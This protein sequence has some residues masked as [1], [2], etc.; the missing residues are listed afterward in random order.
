MEQ[1]GEW[2]EV[3]G[4]AKVLPLPQE[5][6]D[7]Y[8]AQYNEVDNLFNETLNGLQDLDVPSGFAGQETKPL[9]L[10][11]HQRGHSRKI[12][13]TAIFGYA[14]HTRELSVNGLT[15]DFYKNGKPS[16]DLGKS[17]SPGQLLKNLGNSSIQTNNIATK[18]ELVVPPPILLNEEDE[19]EQQGSSSSNTAKQ[20]DKDYIVTNMCPKSYKFPPSPSPTR[21]NGNEFRMSNDN[22]TNF[23]PVNSY[24]AKYL[25]NLRYSDTKRAGIDYVDDITPLLENSTNEHAIRTNH[26]DNITGFQ[27]DELLSML[28]TPFS[29]QVYKYVSIPVQEPDAQ[30]KNIMNNN[31]QQEFKNEA[32]ILPPP[33]PP[34][35]SNGSP[36]WQSSPEPQSPSPVRTSLGKFSSPDKGLANHKPSFYKLQFFSDP[37]S[38][39]AGIN[40][41]DYQIQSS[42]VYEASSLN[43]SPI[44]YYDKDSK[45]MFNDD[46]LVDANATITQ[47]TPLKN[48][49]PNTPSKNNVTLEWSP[50]ISPN[51]KA[52]K[53]VKKH[54][55]QTTLRRKVKKTSLLPPGELD[56]F[57]EGPD[58]NKV[59]TCT[60][61][62]CGK[63]FT[64]RYNVRSHIQTHLSDRPFACSYCPKKFVR[65]HDLNRHVKGHLDARYCKCPCGKEFA[66]LDAM[67]K[68]RERNICIGG[69]ASNTNNYVT[70]PQKKGKHETLDS[71]KC[72]KLNE[73]LSFPEKLNPFLSET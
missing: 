61:R 25:Q 56:R 51:E 26:Q 49:F 1:Y 21:Y 11:V 22:E 29:K 8:F 66:R 12:S 41:L 14:E 47:L 45:E 27:Q 71:I 69:I 5:E 31:F 54:I 60:Y 55:Q 67:K 42:P 72:E 20:Q 13:G 39:N 44:K 48:R 2:D 28:S 19:N 68:H 58:E 24:S 52:S 16:L 18:E 37:D 63:K 36:E 64:R 23:T 32:T 30:K 50:I 43:S 7:Q 38:S 34:T 46:D 35:L 3:S 40:D 6:F 70:K 59:F 4:A 65:Q 73:E 33:S 17:I 9:R 62:N 57:W 15:N 10:L 53:D